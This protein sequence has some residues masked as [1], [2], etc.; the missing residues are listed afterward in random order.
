MWLYVCSSCGWREEKQF[1]SSCGTEFKI[2]VEGSKEAN[3]Q[4]DIELTS[5]TTSNG[6][7]GKF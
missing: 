5:K 7:I 3:K 1:C 4:D 2:T 6:I